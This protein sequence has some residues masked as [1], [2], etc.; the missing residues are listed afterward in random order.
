[1]DLASVGLGLLLAVLLAISIGGLIKGL[2]G[3]GLPIFGVPALA[4]ITSVEEA[5]VL[6]LFPSI[7]ANLWL[8]VSHRKYA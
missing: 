1:M 2:T 5:V 6:M 3:V 4:A 7:D 8:V